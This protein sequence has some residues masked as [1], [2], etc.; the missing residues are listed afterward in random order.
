MTELN[1][2]DSIEQRTRESL[3]TLLDLNNQ[4]NVD[5][6]IDEL[7]DIHG[8]YCDRFDYFS[9]YISSL[10]KRNI[11][12]SGCAV[13]SEMIV[14]K[15]YGFSK[16]YGTEISSDLVKIGKARLKRFQEM[17]INYIKG[18]KLPFA[19][20]SFTMVYS[21]HII[22]HTTDPFMY[23]KE[24]LRVLKKEGILFIE[25]PNRYWITELHT[26][27]LSFEYLP[28]SLRNIILKKLS[29]K[30]VGYNAVLTGLKPVSIWQVRYYCWRSNYKTRLINVNKPAPGFVRIIISKQ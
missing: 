17:N 27:L 7:M 8:G 20:E 25:F 1:L 28:L 30:F 15:R 22:E 9:K 11:L 10:N 2:D 21:G 5:K 12:I 13:G 18:N 3:R 24:H 19:D 6:N 29:N 23:L 26:G 14:A 4:K 16:I